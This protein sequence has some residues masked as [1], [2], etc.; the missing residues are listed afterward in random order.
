M[1]LRIIRPEA[2]SGGSGVARGGGGGAGGGGGG[3]RG[4]GGGEQGAMP[5]IQEKIGWW[6]MED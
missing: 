5:P 4:A 1:L 2:E 6:G 3:S